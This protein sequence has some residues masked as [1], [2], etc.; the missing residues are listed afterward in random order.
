MFNVKFNLFIEAEIVPL[1]DK[2][3]V[4]SQVSSFPQS[5]NPDFGN[6]VLKHVHPKIFLKGDFLLEYRPDLLAM[7]ICLADFTFL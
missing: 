7:Q 4:E 1:I 6:I 3:F 2:L 5:L